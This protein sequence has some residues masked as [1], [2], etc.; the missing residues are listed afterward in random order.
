MRR[1]VLCV[2]AGGALVLAPP[3]WG[4]DF[5][6]VDSCAT[7]TGAAASADGWTFNRAGTQS[8][9]CPRPGI[10][11]SEP[12]SASTVLQ[13]FNTTFSAPAGARILGYRLWRS[14]SLR[15]NWNYT[16]YRGAAS[17]REEDIVERCWTLGG[18]CTS[19]GDARNTGAPHVSQSRLDTPALVFHVDCN[20]GDCPGGGP[21]NVTVNRLQVDLTDS[22]DP[23]LIGTPSGDLVDT[24]QPISGVRTVSFSATDQGGGV[25]FARVEVDGSTM[26]SSVV[27]SNGGRCVKPF[28][29]LVPCR[30]TASGSVSLDTGALPDGVHSIR[31]L[32]YDATESNS[33]AY[34]PVSVRTANQSIACAPGR[35]E[36]LTVR[37]ASTRRSALTRRGGKALTLT[38]VLAGA[39]P[40]T[41]VA[42]LS[43]EV[44]TGAPRIAVQNAI[45]GEGGAFRIGVPAGRSRSLQV[46]YRPTATDPLL[47]CSRALRLRVP[48][49]V[50]FSARRSGVRRFR[51]SGRLIGGGVPARGKVVELQGYE[52]GRW[53]E[54]RT[55]R[56]RADGRFAATYRFKAASA[57]RRFR[58]RVRVRTDPS[59]AFST[60]YSR[61]VRLRVR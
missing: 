60:G 45:T 26:A 39:A 59:Y 48:A 7:G 20:P 29:Y 47:R 33:V 18:G 58:V 51:M 43:R 50:S 3:A 24:T 4:Q 17:G 23:T 61:A 25:Y 1:L 52:G 32:V 46:A 55:I 36:E 34:G 54:F 10:V 37:F 35:A 15:P 2:A 13:G 9:T 14:V 30:A 44:R 42:L 40:G 38:G 6:T 12:S 5:Y 57:G 27:D 56:S 22:V 53:R 16:L 21:A 8:R 49:R 11:A 41:A 28:R 31:L 19:L